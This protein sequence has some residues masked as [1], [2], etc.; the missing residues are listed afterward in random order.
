MPSGDN[1]DD[2]LSNA[3]PTSSAT[4]LITD[5]DRYLIKRMVAL[6]AHLMLLNRKQK[7]PA[8]KKWPVAPAVT[9]Q[10]AENHLARG[11]NLGVNLRLSNLVVLD[12]ENSAAT[13]SLRAAGFVPTVIPAKSLMK[14]PLNPADDKRGGSHVWLRVPTGID[15]YHLASDRIGIMLPGGG[16]IDVLAG[17]RFIVAPP[18]SLDA[19]PDKTY[20]AGLHGALD[21]AVQC[22]LDVAPLWLF[23]PNAAA[24][25]T[26]P[27]LRPFERGCPADLEPLRGILVPDPP[28]VRVARDA[29]SAE[30]SSEIDSVSWDDWINADARM[31]PTAQHDTC[32]CQIW[33]WHGA[34]N[35][36]SATLHENCAEMGNGAHIWSG[37]MRRDLDVDALHLSRLDLAVALRGGGGLDGGE[38]SR[39][40]RSVAADVG[41]HLGAEPQDFDVVTPD[42]YRR[43]ADTAEM[44]GDRAGAASYRSMAARMQRFIERDSLEGRLLTG[45]HDAGSTVAGAVDNRSPGDIPIVDAPAG[46]ATDGAAERKSPYGGRVRVVNNTTIRSFPGVPLDD[47]P[48]PRENEMHE[49]PMPDPPPEFTTVWGARTE[50]L[51]VLPP[52]ANRALHRYVKHEWIFAATPGLSHVAAAADSH[53]VSR[54]GLL[55][56]LLPRIVARIPAT[57]RLV[58]PDRSIPDGDQ[59]TAAGTSLNLYSVIIG[60]PSSGKSNTMGLAATLV[61]GVTTVPPGTGE[62]VLKKFPRGDDGE[63]ADQ[64]PAA[65]LPGDNIPAVGSVGGGGDRSPSAVLIESDEID[66]FTAEM[67]RQGSKTLGLYRSMWMGGE[68]GNTT[69]DR[70]RHSFVAAHTYRLGI[71]LGAQPGTACKLFDETGKGTPQRFLWLPGHQT[72]TRGPQYPGLL[73]T[74]PVYWFDGKPSMLP[75]SGGPRPPVWITPPAAAIKHMDLDRARAAT[76]NPFHPDGLYPQPSRPW[77][78]GGEDE[79]LTPEDDHLYSDADRGRGKSA[80]EA[81]ANR[82][83]VLQQLKI[84]VALA[85]LDGLAQPQDAHWHAAGAIMAVRRGSIEELVELTEQQR[86]TDLLQRGS[87]MGRMSTEARAAGEAHRLTRV[88]NA[89][90]YLSDAAMTLTEMGQPLTKDSLMQAFAPEGARSLRGFAGDAMR[91]MQTAGQLT[92]LVD[93]SFTYNPFGTPDDSQTTVA[94]VH[95]LHPPPIASVGK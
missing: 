81:I 32:G 36:K 22:D 27:G 14:E 89:R 59:P 83:A 70:E 12:A 65:P 80:A 7:S 11:G 72:V 94:T 44:F 39:L 93:G 23:D 33:Y 29:R 31:H 20:S 42:Y 4:Q 88:E 78:R 68:V 53:G 79:D 1:G 87:D 17:P 25:A 76:A 55:G 34:S 30:L 5:Y 3:G 40:R 95:L 21:S 9:V 64:A 15:P 35:E 63:G 37:T 60:P 6:G 61:P 26:T 24:D 2:T 62:G 69:S 16:K 91:L 8:Y 18:S 75:D 73:A 48:L 90:A 50:M 58:P 38:R 28:Q 43:L 57:V 67:L 41:I 52:L 56:A 86:E 45:Q 51:Q 54:W 47:M 82:H 85:A 71:L 10:E 19:A 46:V 74:Q 66:I 92:L 77:A 49:Y 13:A 84:G